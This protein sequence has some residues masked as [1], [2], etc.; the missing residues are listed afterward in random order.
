MTEL[1]SLYSS[2]WAE[3]VW[4]LA[5]ASDSET[6][7]IVSD[8]PVTV[9][10][11]ACGPRHQWCR[12]A[13]DP[14]IRFHGSHTLFPLGLDR[15]L[16]LTNLSWARNPYQ[17]PTGLR[18]NPAYF[19]DTFFNIFSVQTERRLCEAEVRQINFILKSRAYRQI[20]AAREEWLHPEQFVSKSD[21]A[22][23][24]HG[25]LLMPDPRALHHGGEIMMGF[26]DGS[27]DSF[28]SYGRKPW[29][30]DYGLEGPSRIGR[31]S[32]L[33]FQGEFARLFGPYRRGRSF[34]AGRLDGERDGD[35][36]HAYHLGLER[37][38]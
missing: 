10:N 29:D 24:G 8:H 34:E 33:R 20:A 36:F 6:K 13:N 28:D 30:D 35:D 26:A 25:Y 14:D 38:R 17:S 2:I 4:Q 15:V 21:W 12:G 27:T 22:T 37:G 31:D 11:R 3:C 9:Y 1:R 7:F 5:D 16:I 18:P 19:R 32:L 23:Y